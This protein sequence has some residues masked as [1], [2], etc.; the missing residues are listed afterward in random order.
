[1]NSGT[2]SVSGSGGPA[3]V[4]KVCAR[5]PASSTR[6]RFVPGLPGL[7]D[8]LHLPRPAALRLG[9]LVGARVDLVRR[10]EVDVVERA[11]GDRVQ[12]L[13]LADDRAPAAPIDDDLAGVDDELREVEPLERGAVVGVSQS[14]PGRS[15]VSVC[16]P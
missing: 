16:V 3:G 14:I 7:P 9:R 6:Q 12:H 2:G 13:E 11:A 4:G 8:D 1:V 15:Y 10:L 5:F